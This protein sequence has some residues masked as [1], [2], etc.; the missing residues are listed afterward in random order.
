MRIR[1]TKPDG[2]GRIKQYI[3]EKE[4]RDIPIKDLSGMSLPEAAGLLQEG[5]YEGFDGDD[6]ALCDVSMV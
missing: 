2:K 6:S 4:T 5:A 3:A 1:F